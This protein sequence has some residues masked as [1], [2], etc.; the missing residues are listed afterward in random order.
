M[1]KISDQKKKILII[2]SDTKITEQ[3]I[4]EDREE[5]K[6]TD[7]TRTGD[8]ILNAT[9]SFEFSSKEGNRMP[10][11]ATVCFLLLPLGINRTNEKEGTLLQSVGSRET[12]KGKRKQET[13]ER[14]GSVEGRRSNWPLVEFFE[15]RT[16]EQ[17][18]DSEK[19][20]SKVRASGPDTDRFS[21]LRCR[22]RE[23]GGHV[24]WNVSHYAINFFLQKY[25]FHVFYF[26][27]EFLYWCK[28]FFTFYC[29]VDL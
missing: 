18:E 14:R 5:R 10:S 19:E 24:F 16:K 6:R 4:M 7:R 15:R 23:S 12:E 25:I 1:S 21:S 3:V 20:K 26:R 29:T 9:S 13:Q 27:I 8:G 22:R 2:F 17:D 28:N 11:I